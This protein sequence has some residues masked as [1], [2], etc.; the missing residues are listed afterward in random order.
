MSS[1]YPTSRPRAADGIKAR[2]TR[3]EI[4]KTWWSRRFISSLEDS[5]VGGRLARGKN[6]ARRGQVL[7]LNIDTGAVTAAV[8]GSRARPYQVRIGLPALGKADWA[9]VIEALAADAWFA[10][11]LLAGEMPPD[12]EEVFTAAG[13]ALFPASMRELSLDCSC[14]DWG[15]PCK[16]LAAVFYLLAEAFDEDPF[17]VLAWR[18]RDQAAL[19][20]ALAAHRSGGAVADRTEEEAPGPALADQLDH[21]WQRGA[22]PAREQIPQM[23]V[24]AILD[25]LPTVELAVRGAELPELLRP[26]YRALALEVEHDAAIHPG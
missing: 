1:W 11:K 10:A 24:D 5:E 7:Q 21:F 26:V 12:I 3:G 16:H 20:D 9:Q 19:L 25:Q 15:V 14:P 4:A 13:I 17:L 6:Y 8:Q 2:S 18:G 23:A 22:P